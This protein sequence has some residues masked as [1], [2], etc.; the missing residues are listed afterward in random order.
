MSRQTGHTRDCHL[1]VLPK[2]KHCSKV[3]FPLCSKRLGAFSICEYELM[4]E[5]FKSM[6]V[7]AFISDALTGGICKG[8]STK[9]DSAWCRLAGIG[10]IG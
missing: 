2:S 1:V 3:Q 6:F 10:N 4:K 8:S 7:F 5:T 9:R